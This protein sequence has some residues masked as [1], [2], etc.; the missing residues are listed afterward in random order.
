MMIPKPTRLTKIVRKMMRRGRVTAC[1]ILYNHRDVPLRT[2]AIV[3]LAAAAVPLAARASPP[4]E[5][6]AGRAAPRAPGS[7][8]AAGLGGQARRRPP[9]LGCRRRAHH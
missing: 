6:G 4:A 1:H 9:L 5:A 2:I 8:G 3:I 7:P